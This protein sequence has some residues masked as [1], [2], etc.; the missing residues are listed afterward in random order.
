MHEDKLKK[1]TNMKVIRLYIAI[2][3]ALLAINTFTSCDNDTP[4]DWSEVINLYVD[5]EFGEYRPWGHPKDVEPLDGLKIKEHK[6]ANWE[7]I[8]I[9]GIIGFSYIEGYEYYIEVE[10]THLANSPA[11]ASNI[12]YTLIRIISV[13]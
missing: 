12:R 3:I 7:V 6:D 9:N 1:S 10:K 13:H 11:D 8:P 5:S 4:E 2:I